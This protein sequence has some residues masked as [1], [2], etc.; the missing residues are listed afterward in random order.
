MKTAFLNRMLMTTIAASSIATACG[1]GAP[2]QDGATAAAEVTAAWSKAFDGG[3]PTALAALYAEE[4]RSLGASGAPRV[5][6]SEIE[7]YWRSDIGEGGVT[8]ALTVS[9]SMAQGDLLHVEGAYQV[10]GAQEPE[11]ARGQFQQ[12]WRRGNDGWRVEREMWRMDPALVRSTDVAHRLTS[13]WTAA[14]NAGN[15][16]ALAGLYA[17]D[18]VLS[19]IQEGSFEG[20]TAIE[21][22]WTRDFGDGKPSSALTLTDVYLSGELAHLEGEY[23]VAGRGASTEGRYVQLWMRDGNEW[24]IHREMWLR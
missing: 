21:S 20:P 16:K 11:L 9:D 13:A 15:A 1:T 22:F 18:G 5:G 12:L 14:Y 24:R 7:R 23:T 10:K 19:T 17:G 2:A 8:T 3:D 4:A 6:R